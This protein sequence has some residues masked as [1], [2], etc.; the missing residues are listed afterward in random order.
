VQSGSGL[1]YAFQYAGVLD[2]SLD[3]NLEPYVI[4]PSS[5]IGEDYVITP[6]IRETDYSPADWSFA[7]EIDARQGRL[8]GVR[9][10]VSPANPY[11]TSLPSDPNDTSDFYDSAVLVIFAEFYPIPAAFSEGEFNNF[12]TRNTPSANDDLRPVFSFNLAVR[13]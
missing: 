6:V 13:R 3:E 4:Q 10:S 1:V 11:G 8:F 5:V 12:V 9:L 2:T 7:D